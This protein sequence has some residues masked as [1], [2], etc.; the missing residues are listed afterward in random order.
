MQ[1]LL[2]MFRS[3]SEPQR[4]DV[5]V[6]G[7][8]TPLAFDGLQ[9]DIVRDDTLDVDP[10]LLSAVLFNLLDNSRR[11]QARRVMLM[12]SQ[13]AG[14]NRLRLHDD[15]EG[16]PAE[17]LQRLRDALAKQDYCSGSGLKGLGMILADLV[18]RAHGG[19]IG[20]PTMERGFCVEL[21]WP[22][23]GKP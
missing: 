23:H 8:L 5:R 2:T 22:T 16:C 12:A 20:L 19:E 1:A 13:E 14:I 15:G 11:H 10:D 18:V 7:L 4:Q 6:S 9:L 21:N 3:G 17:Q